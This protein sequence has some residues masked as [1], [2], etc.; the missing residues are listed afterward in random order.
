[1]KKL[2][3]TIERFCPLCEQEARDRESMLTFLAANPDAATR[4]NRTAHLTASA[5]AVNPA[6]DK[7]VMIYHNIYRS[8]SWTG[9]HADGDFDLRA[10]AL[11]ELCEETGARGRAVSSEP[12]S[13]EVLTVDGHIKRG[14]YV[15]SHLHLNLTYLI[16]ADETEPLRIKPDEN[17]GARFIPVSQVAS[18][19]SEPWMMTHVYQKLIDRVREQTAHNTR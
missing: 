17:G 10:V 4:E 9:G 8:W 7:V 5:W 11:R 3:E 14:A 16:E 15:S 2:I 6:R 13:L 1:M 12:L 18:F 19:V